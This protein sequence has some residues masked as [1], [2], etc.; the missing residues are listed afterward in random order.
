M[1]RLL[2]LLPLLL[3]PAAC[4]ADARDRLPVRGAWAVAVDTT[5][6]PRFSGDSAHA[7]LR[8]QVAFGPR[9][10]GSPGHAAQL[11]WMTA[12]LRERADTVM[13]QPFAH[14]TRAST[15]LQLT[16]V[17]AQ[18]RPELETRILLVAH[19]DTRP[20]ADMDTER[21]DEPIPGANDGASGVAVLLELANVLSRHSPPIGVDILLVD[22][23]DYG[24]GEADMYLGA[25]V[26]ARNQ[27]PGYR[28]LYGIVVDMVADTDPVFPMEGYSVDLAP[29]VVDRVWSVAEQIGLGHIFV[30]RRGGYVTDDHLPLNRAG[31]RT[32]DIIDFDYGPDNAFWHTH[33]DVVENT[34]PVGLDAVGRVLTALIFSGG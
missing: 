17:F 26:F 34:S 4:S 6:V 23:E 24:P 1:R 2:F 22:G 14:R 12:F 18:F 8:A 5:R 9:V 11:A 33:Q 27:P 25:S 19:W 20:T 21:R 28:P 7:L 13:H 15:V 3:L 16:N 30:R 31:I 29:E 10:P 32:I